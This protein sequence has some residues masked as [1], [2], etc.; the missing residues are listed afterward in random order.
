MINTQVSSPPSTLWVGLT[1][2]GVFQCQQTD[3]GW[4]AHS[5]NSN[6][7]AVYGE[8]LPHQAAA[9]AVLWQV[10]LAN[11]QPLLMVNKHYLPDSSEQL[12]QIIGRL[13]GGTLTLE[14]FSTY[15]AQS[16]PVQDIET[17]FTQLNCPQPFF[18]GAVNGPTFSYQRLVDGT[19][20][21][22][23]AVGDPAVEE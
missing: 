8:D 1:A 11:G 10:I 6:A 18:K 22:I 17:A 4:Q 7:T 13:H 23:N 14:C 16:C 20:T 12:K 15:H 19:G 9:L 3:T 2:E 21:V 5:V